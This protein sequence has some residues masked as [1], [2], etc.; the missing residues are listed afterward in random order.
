MLQT[1]DETNYIYTFIQNYIQHVID[2]KWS[3]T[4]QFNMEH[5]VFRC[6]PSFANGTGRLYNNKG[7]YS[8]VIPTAMPYGIDDCR[9]IT[10]TQRTIIG[11][12]VIDVGRES[13]YRFP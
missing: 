8:L 1:L 11:Y 7:F 13:G 2:Y 4:V 12:S 9:Y 10:T 5:N 6:S 3:N